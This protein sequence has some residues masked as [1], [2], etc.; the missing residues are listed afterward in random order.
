MGARKPLI[1]FCKPLIDDCKHS[2][3]CCKILIISPKPV[4]FFI[5]VSALIKS[6]TKL[7][8]LIV[9]I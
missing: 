8:N 7:T 9:K 1:F 6:F 5:I 2:I 4:N 3:V